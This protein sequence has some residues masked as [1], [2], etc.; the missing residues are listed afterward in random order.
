M[1]AKVMVLANK[2][3]IYRPPN[4]SINCLDYELSNSLIE[5]LL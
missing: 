3:D 2:F 1:L 4:T 5:T